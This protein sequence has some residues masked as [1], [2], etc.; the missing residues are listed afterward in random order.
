M[1][2]GDFIIYGKLSEEFLCAI[3]MVV[4]RVYFKTVL[5]HVTEPATQDTVV[6][7]EVKLPAK[8][9]I[10][11]NITIKVNSLLPSDQFQFYLQVCT[12]LC[13]RSQNLLGMTEVYHKEII[14]TAI[15]WAAI[16]TL[17]YQNTKKSEI[18]LTAVFGP[19]F[20][21]HMYSRYTSCPLPVGHVWELTTKTPSELINY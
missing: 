16:S 10:Y 15:L 20:K 6:S 1:S 18:H 3:W 14:K 11:F 19:I 2:N 13:L 8:F 5:L 9:K 4:W 7:Y 17:D 21:L 12:Q